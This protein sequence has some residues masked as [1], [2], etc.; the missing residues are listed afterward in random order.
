VTPAHPAFRKIRTAIVGLGFG[1]EFIPI[2]QHHPHA[3]LVAIWQR[4]RNKL[5]QVGKAYGVERRYQ[6]YSDLLKDR[7]TDAFPTSFPVFS[8]DK[9]FRSKTVPKLSA[10]LFRPA[11]GGCPVRC[12]VAGTSKPHGLLSVLHVGQLVKLADAGGSGY[13]ITVIEGGPQNLA[14]KVV[15]I[16]SDFVVLEEFTGVQQLRI[17]VYSLK[18]VGIKKIPAGK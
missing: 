12:L 2:H 9:P 5:D 4:S 6:S 7:E 1:A 8:A 16:G 11:A 17:P 18:S 3:E 15:E 14:H 13:E 10:P